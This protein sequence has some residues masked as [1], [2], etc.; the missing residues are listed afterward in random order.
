VKRC[1]FPKHIFWRWIQDQF[2]GKFDLRLRDASIGAPIPSSLARPTNCAGFRSNTGNGPMA[3]SS[4]DPPIDDIELVGWMAGALREDAIP[5]ALGDALARRIED[6][7][8]GLNGEEALAMLL[9]AMR[10]R[11]WAEDKRRRL[12]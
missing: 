6:L 7:A 10:I 8:S 1:V 5:P 9:T 12:S 3:P 4:D 2:F 11:L